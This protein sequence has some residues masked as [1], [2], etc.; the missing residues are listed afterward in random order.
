MSAEKMMTDAALKTAQ[1][2]EKGVEQFIKKAWS[3]MDAAA[4]KQKASEYLSDK[5]IKAI[6]GQGN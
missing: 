2:V 1:N 4:E 6:Q 5:G 3:V